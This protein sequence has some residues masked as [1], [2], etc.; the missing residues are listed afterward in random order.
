MMLL[1]MV[2]LGILISAS[3]WVLLHVLFIL[4]CYCLMNQTGEDIV[5]LVAPM[6]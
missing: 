4:L 6:M 1:G 3:R 5:K 2:L